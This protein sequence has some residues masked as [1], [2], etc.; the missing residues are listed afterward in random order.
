MQLLDKLRD[1]PYNIVADKEYYEKGYKYLIGVPGRVL[2]AK[3]LSSLAFFPFF[4][5]N[6]IAS[7]LFNEGVIQGFDVVNDAKLENGSIFGLTI[8][9]VD[10]LDEFKLYDIDEFGTITEISIDL[11]ELEEIEVIDE[12]D[13]DQEESDDTG[14]ITDD[15]KHRVIVIPH[16]GSDDFPKDLYIKGLK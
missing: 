13:D 2:Q 7:E 9:G 6:D 15:L 11:S 10:P 8:T 12:P 5:L 4:A 16:T 1:K 3:E 14:G